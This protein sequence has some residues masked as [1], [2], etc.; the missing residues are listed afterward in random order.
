[1]TEPT[2]EPKIRDEVIAR[3]WQTNEVIQGDVCAVLDSTDGRRVR[4]LSGSLVRTVD[5]AMK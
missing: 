2:I 5:A 4:I 1:M 3:L